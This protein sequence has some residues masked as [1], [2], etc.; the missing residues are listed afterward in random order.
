LTVASCVQFRQAEENGRL[1]SFFA[2]VFCA[3]HV[4]RPCDA[5]LQ[6]AACSI[7][8]DENQVESVQVVNKVSF[9]LSTLQLS[10]YFFKKNYS[11]VTF[12]GDLGTKVKLTC[13]FYGLE[14]WYRVAI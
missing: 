13:Q 9:L 1:I 6:P 3:V 4:H 14:R 11:R 5:D 8:P 12:H 7:P 10:K 2:C